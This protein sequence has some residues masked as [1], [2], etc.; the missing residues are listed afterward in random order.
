VPGFFQP[1]EI[2][3]PSGV[4]ISLAEAGAFREADAAP[5]TVGLLI[6]Q[7]YRIRVMNVPLNPG[8]EVFPSIEVIDRLYTPAGREHQFPIVVQLTMEDLRLALE[9]KFVSRVIYLEDPHAALPYPA[10]PERQNW[11]E[12]APGRDPLAIADQMGRPVAILRLGA[13]L[14]DDGVAPDMGFLF[15]CPPFV[16]Y[17]P[18]EQTGAP[19]SPQQTPQPPA[20]QEAPAHARQASYRPGRP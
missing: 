18:S 12:V 7:V 11:F 10:D 3:A 4:S 5:V 16:D 17:P 20:P 13:R 9:G 2:Q 6:G 15:G 19:A 8:L 14:P 1:V